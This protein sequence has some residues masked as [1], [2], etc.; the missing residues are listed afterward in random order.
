MRRSGIDK[1]LAVAGAIALIGITSCRQAA[2]PVIEDFDTYQMVTIGPAHYTTPAGVRDT[3]HGRGFVEHKVEGLDG[4]TVRVNVD[5]NPPRDVKFD[6][7]AEKRKFLDDLHGSFLRSV[8]YSEY[9]G[10]QKIKII[11]HSVDKA[12]TPLYGTLMMVR[13]GSN[14]ATIRAVGPRDKQTEMNRLVETLA[15]E[16]KLDTPEVIEAPEGEMDTT[17]TLAVLPPLPMAEAKTPGT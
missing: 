12:G 3:R 10:T 1:L 9:K 7:D 8:Q 17:D 13:A 2:V 5:P 15:N 4:V 14:T 16:M 11:A 6:A